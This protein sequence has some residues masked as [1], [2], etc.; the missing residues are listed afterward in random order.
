[1]TYT[2]MRL[3]DATTKWEPVFALRCEDGT[4]KTGVQMRQGRSHWTNVGHLLMTMR[5]L[6]P[7]CQIVWEGSIY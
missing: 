2:L 4:I 5:E 1:M 7:D 3:V 6:E